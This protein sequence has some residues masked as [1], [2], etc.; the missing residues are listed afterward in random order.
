MK[1]TILTKTL[2][3]E[4][5]KLIRSINDIAEAKRIMEVIQEK[6]LFGKSIVNTKFC[7]EKENYLEHE[8]LNY[9][10]HSGEYTESMGYDV[11]E[12][13]IKLGLDFFEN[14]IYG[15]DLLPHNFTYRNGTWFLYDF[16]GFSLDPKRIITQLRGFFK[17]N[18]SNYEILRFLTRSEM[19]SFYLTRIKMEDII[20]SIPL[21]RGLYLFINMTICKILHY[22]RMYKLVYKYLNFL[23]KQYSKN[24]KKEYFEYNLKENEKEEFCSIAEKLSNVQNIFCIGEL[25][26]KWAIFDE[27]RNSLINK[28]VYIDDYVIC[29]KYY[30]YIYKNQLKNISTGVLYPLVDNANI[31]QTEY[32]AL[33]DTYAQFRFISDAVLSFEVDDVEVL[34]NFT[35]DLLIV[36]SERDLSSELEKH[37][38]NIEKQ[39]NL[40]IAK[41]KKDKT[42]PLPNKK[43]ND[44]NRGYYSNKHT[45]EILKILKNKR[46]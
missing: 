1:D 25:A 33:Y 36:K 24:Y 12:Y 10:I 17:I 3:I 9:I 23:F 2:K 41:D 19:S 39:G 43:Y 44:G 42:K 16:D 4:N 27:E 20:K 34:K 40:Y 6:G 8:Y 11:Q 18:F 28:F 26:G 15:W 30:N 46:K 37:F 45:L 7:S 32:R 21:Y 13:A 22:L 35:T 5:G 31:E 29:D 38:N 14:G